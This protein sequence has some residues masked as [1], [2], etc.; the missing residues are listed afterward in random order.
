MLKRI[1]AI[2]ALLRSEQAKTIRSSVTW[3]S[4]LSAAIVYTPLFLL[5]TAVLVLDIRQTILGPSDILTLGQLGY[6]L[7]YA[8]LVAPFCLFV[9]WQ[10]LR[11]LISAEQYIFREVLLERPAPR[12]RSVVFTVTFPDH[13]DQTI[14]TE[15]LQVPMTMIS[16]T[17]S[18]ALVAYN[19]ATRLTVL[20]RP[21]ADTPTDSATT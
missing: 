13:L 9:I 10:P 11:L 16:H 21:L 14:Q 6:Y 8:F 20:I 2:P 3:R 7:L 15:I 19:P 17:G 5:C 18:P 4:Y 1:L 12:Y